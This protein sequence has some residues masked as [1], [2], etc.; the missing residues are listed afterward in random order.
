LV[1]NSAPFDDVLVVPPVE[2]PQVN[3]ACHIGIRFKEGHVALISQIKWFLSDIQD[4]SIYADETKLQGSNDGTIYS[5]I[6]TMDENVHDGW[7]Y[8]KWTEPADYPRYR[9]YR[10]Y[11]TKAG[12]CVIN[13]I[14]ATGVETVDS[15]DQNKACS[16]VV[17]I[18]GT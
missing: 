1:D 16:A 5:D 12:S 6:F 11:G 13:E 3:G 9:Y 4:K 17:D 8:H 2:G 10:F 14:K 7:N 18:N 15:P